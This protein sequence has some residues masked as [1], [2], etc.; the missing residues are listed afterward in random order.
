MKVLVYGAGV[1]GSV[2]AARL[3]NAGCEVSLLARGQRLQDL[4]ENGIILEQALTGDRTITRINAV[5][6]LSADDVYDL[7]IVT[8]RKNQVAAILPILAAHH[9][10]PNVLFMINNP[11]GYDDWLQ[12]VGRE[13][14]LLGFP[15]AGGTLEGPIVRYIISARQLQPTTL[16]EPDGQMTAR[17]KAIV[18][19]FK[20]AGFPVAISNNMDAW[21]KTH[22][23]LIS[24]IADAL[25]MAGG[26]NYRLAQMP[27][28]LHLM[29]QAIREGFQ[30]LRSLGMPIT[31][32]KFQLWAWLPE[33]VLVA[34][35]RR[36]VSTRYFEIV[37][38]RHANAARDEMQQ[39]AKEFQTLAHQASID[40]P[41]ID[42]LETYIDLLRPGGFEIAS[43]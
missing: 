13:R 5:E 26:D 28:A 32:A 14:L 40:T 18:S 23:A 37:I 25:Y 11:S 41:A 33:A 35:L 36:W 8:M 3:Q 4:R 12:A 2:Y 1:I 10:S 38:A 27:E 17:L 15:G 9:Q 21:Q 20:Q 16:G 29:V 19:Q 42:Q 22:V 39:L 43:S 30:V 34:V 7:I 31:P 24:P 6:Q